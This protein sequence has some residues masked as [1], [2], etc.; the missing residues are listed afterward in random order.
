MYLTQVKFIDMQNSVLDDGKIPELKK[1]IGVLDGKL[2]DIRGKTTDAEKQREIL[3]KAIEEARKELKI[4]EEEFAKNLKEWQRTGRF[5]FKKKVY[6]AYRDKVYRPKFYLQWNR[7]D[8]HDIRNWEAQWGYELVVA[9]KDPFWPEGIKPNKE[10]HFTF[11]DA[12]LMK[13]PFLKYLIKRV[14]AI[15][16]SERG[17]DDRLEKFKA[18]VEGS[19]GVVPEEFIGEVMDKYGL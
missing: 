2:K 1:T 15:S 3:K 7:D 12:I 8:S 17:L 6:V 5:K 18:D 19:G 10:G 13:I 9:G 14:E 4:E 11:G 16:L